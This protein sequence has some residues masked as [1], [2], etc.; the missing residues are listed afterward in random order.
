MPDHLRVAIKPVVIGATLGL[1]RSEG[2]KKDIM[3]KRCSK[4]SNRVHY[5]RLSMKEKI[6]KKDFCDWS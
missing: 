4:G 3:L 5:I 6:N 1:F 2:K